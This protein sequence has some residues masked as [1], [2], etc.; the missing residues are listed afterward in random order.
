[1]SC[2]RARVAYVKLVPLSAEE[3]GSC[4]GSGPERGT[5]RLYAVNDA[6]GCMPTSG[7]PRRRR[8]AASWSLPRHRFPGASIGSAA[9][10]TLAVL[11]GQ[12]RPDPDLRRAHRLPLGQRA[13]PLRVLAD[14]PRAGARPVSIA[15]DYAREI[16]MEFMPAIGS[17]ASSS[18][19]I[20]TTSTT[21]TRST[22]GTPSC[23]APRETVRRRRGSPMPTPRPA[24]S[25]SV[26]CA[27]S[28]PPTTSTASAW[29]TTAGLRWS[30]TSRPWWP[31]SGPSW[32]STRSTWTPPTAAGSPTEPVSS[33]AS[34]G[35]ARGDGL[36]RAGARPPA[37]LRLRD[38]DGERGREPADGHGPAGLDR[39]GAH[40]HDH[41]YTSVPA[42]DSTQESWI[43][44]QTAP[45]SCRS[46]RGPHARSPST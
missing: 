17:P 28:P 39:A 4:S 22:T 24:A 29:P 8:S 32:G 12:R 10:A 14:L 31:A 1:M 36:A 43:D 15:R 44:P 35:G 13:L 38:R 3:C 20:T 25:R 23:A 46:P 42:L 21:A 26:C 27:R 18:P 6:H 33:P 34:A 45:G 2:P 7:P 41:P 5:R 19:P 16:G 30:S 11:P 37:D 9:W 40:R